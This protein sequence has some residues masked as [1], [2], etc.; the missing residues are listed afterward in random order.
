[1]LIRFWK[2]DILTRVELCCH[3]QGEIYPDCYLAAISHLLSFISSKP[4][5]V[6]VSVCSSMVFRALETCGLYKNGIQYPFS[7]EVFLPSKNLCN[8]MFCRP[9]MS[10]DVSTC[11]HNSKIRS[12]SCEDARASPGPFSVPSFAR[13]LSYLIFFHNLI[14]CSLLCRPVVTTFL[15]HSRRPALQYYSVFHLQVS[16]SCD[17]QL[18]KIPSLC[19]ELIK[20]WKAIFEFMAKAAHHKCCRES[21]IKFVHLWF[22]ILHLVRISIPVLQFGQRFPCSPFAL[23]ISATKSGMGDSPR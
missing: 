19:S 14:L 18:R 2:D 17:I 8:R 23:F 12:F 21:K 16:A 7:F 10:L 4:S 15:R 22:S 6:S 13:F 1:M 9:S 11:S 20:H 5:L 3:H